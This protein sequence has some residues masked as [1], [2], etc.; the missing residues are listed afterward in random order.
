MPGD[1]FGF[2]FAYPFAFFPSSRRLYANSLLLFEHSLKRDIYLRTECFGTLIMAHQVD[3]YIF[4]ALITL[5]LYKW[6]SIKARA[7]ALALGAQIRV[8]GIPSMVG[9][10]GK[11]KD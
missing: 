6:Q 3:I 1:T 8:A 10:S 9:L 7:S 5:T 2:G 4:L 11:G